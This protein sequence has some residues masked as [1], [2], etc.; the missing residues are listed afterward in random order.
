MEAA[1]CAVREKCE[2]DGRPAKAGGDADALSGT[3]EWLLGCTGWAGAWLASR[4]CCVLLPLAL[5]VLPGLKPRL[6]VSGGRPLPP[7][8]EGGPLLKP[9]AGL[10]ADALTRA[11]ALGL[12]LLGVWCTDE[13]AASAAAEAP[14]NE[15]PP[16]PRALSARRL[17]LA[18][19][20]EASA[21][22]VGAC[23]RAE[24]GMAPPA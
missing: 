3:V 11:E 21:G 23:W 8:P 14:S 24:E 17:M 20:G 18:E 13:A 7:P 1:G 2:L 16:P 10:V 22:V 6:G 15:K 19:A 12:E 4:C 5:G 9:A